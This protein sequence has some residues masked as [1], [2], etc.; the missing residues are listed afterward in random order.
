MQNLQLLRYLRELESS[1]DETRENAAR[2]IGGIGD[3]IAVPALIKALSDPDVDVR[4]EATKALGRLKSKNA[5]KQLIRL[6]NEE[7][8]PD[9]CAEAVA[10]LGEIGL[11]GAIGPLIKK[12][13]DSDRFV[14]A[15]AA[16]ALGNLGEMGAVE[17][18]IHLM[19]NDG[20][21][22]V[23]EAATEALVEIGGPEAERAI[24]RVGIDPEKLKQE[25]K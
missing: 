13:D 15:S 24:R 11:P 14:R 7:D 6:L 5:F 9:I 21:S 3:P 16:R 8:D 19:R 4:F 22:D 18:L 25:N 12:L 17:S 10:A 20:I 1:A 23:R 2:E